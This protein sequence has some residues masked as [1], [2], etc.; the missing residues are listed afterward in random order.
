MSLWSGG[1]G[2]NREMVCLG[3]L[4]MEPVDTARQISPTLGVNRDWP[5]PVVQLT[6]ELAKR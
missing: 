5:K 6:E 3:D 1:S 4:I 2:A